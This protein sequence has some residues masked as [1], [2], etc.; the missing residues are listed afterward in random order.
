MIWAVTLMKNK[1]KTRD[2][3][4]RTL[5]KLGLPSHIGGAVTVKRFYW[6][7][8][9]EQQVQANTDGSLHGRTSGVGISFRNN[10][11]DFLMVVAQRLEE[12]DIYWAESLAIVRAAEIAVNNGW[13]DLWVESDSSSAVHNSMETEIQMGVMCEGSQ[14]Y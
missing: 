7:P 3:D 8:P 4:N 9:I 1:T 5:S 2:D 13:R 10:C 11:G 12:D 14:Q 6:F